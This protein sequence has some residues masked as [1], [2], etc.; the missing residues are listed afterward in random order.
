MWDILIYVAFMML[1]GTCVYLLLENRTLKTLVTIREDENKTTEAFLETLLENM[2]EGV[3][4]CDVDG[5]IIYHNQAATPYVPLNNILD[6]SQRSHDFIDHL[7]QPL[8]LDR[9]PLSRALRGESI[10]N[11]EIKSISKNDGTQS[12]LL[13]NGR[14]LNN[15]QAQQGGAVIVFHDITEFKE[16][17]ERMRYLA[18][19]DAL[20]ELP[21]RHYFKDQAMNVLHNARK[22]GEQCALLF[23]DIDQFKTVNDTFGHDAGDQLLRE[24]SRRMLDCIGDE[25]VVTRFGGDEFIILL[26]Q[27]E[28]IAATQRAQSLLRAFEAPFNIKKT[29]IYVSPSIGISLYPRDGRT[30]EILVK[31]ADQA[32]YQAKRQGKNTYAVYSVNQ[33]T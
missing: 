18:Y 5:N 11:V 15:I 10:K 26:D 31:R 32:M 13:M 21:N 3:V 28:E 8:S 29:S 24:V 30:L 23:I 4:A 7:G 2:E 33:N 9:L 19:Y 12:T 6:E 1:T 14:P 22:L 27:T 20:T 16:A 25:G 17:Q